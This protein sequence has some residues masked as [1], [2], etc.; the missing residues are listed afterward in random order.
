MPPRYE[1]STTRL[2]TSVSLASSTTSPLFVALLVFVTRGSAD[3]PDDQ[4]AEPGTGRRTAGPPP[5][6]RCPGFS[7]IPPLRGGTLKGAGRTTMVS[8]G[9]DA[10]STAARLLKGACCVPVP[11]GDAVALTNQ[12]DGRPCDADADPGM[13][14]KRSIATKAPHKGIARNSVRLANREDIPELL[15]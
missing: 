6:S 4:F 14:A 1:P 10:C 7:A 15:S 11:P 8:P 13:A 12:V 3:S 2:V 5:T 9:P